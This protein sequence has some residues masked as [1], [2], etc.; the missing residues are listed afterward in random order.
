MRLLKADL[1]F[2]LLLGEESL[3]DALRSLADFLEKNQGNIDRPSISHG[4]SHHSFVWNN[5]LGVR[6]QGKAAIFDLRNGGVWVR[7]DAP[8]TDTFICR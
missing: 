1:I 6:L 5:R 8:G 2:E 3:P 4:L 7:V